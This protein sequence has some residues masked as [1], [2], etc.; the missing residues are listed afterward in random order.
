M[1]CRP[2]AL[3]ECRDTDGTTVS[4]VLDERPALFRTFTNRSRSR[5]KRNEKHICYKYSSK[6]PVRRASAEQASDLLDSP[7]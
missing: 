7:T 6:N 3:V 4:P 5:E 2:L 1:I